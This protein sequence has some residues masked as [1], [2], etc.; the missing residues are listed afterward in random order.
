MRYVP[1][2]YSLILSHS[3]GPHA[4]IKARREVFQCVGISEVDTDTACYHA[5]DLRLTIVTHRF[6]EVTNTHR[7]TRLAITYPVRSLSL[8]V[9]APP[10]APSCSVWPT[11]VQVCVASA[12]RTSRSYRESQYEHGKPCS[13]ISE[14]SHPHRCIG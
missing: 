10:L 2:K 11:P 8:Q 7:R 1:H 6:S 14:H 4:R 9:L 3:T 13:F 5:L 12:S